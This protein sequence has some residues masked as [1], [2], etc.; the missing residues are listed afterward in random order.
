MMHG[1]YKHSWMRIQKTA[2][3]TTHNPSVTA[4]NRVSD[5]EGEDAESQMV[6][7]QA[8]MRQIGLTSDHY[9]RRSEP[10]PASLVAASS[11]C[12]MPDASI[13]ELLQDPT[14]LPHS[15]EAI[16]LHCLMTDLCRDFQSSSLAASQAENKVAVTALSTRALTL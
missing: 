2:W 8:L 5:A 12:A 11:I 10:L 15:G 7:R 16:P 4:A 14:L 1:S 13:Y 9:L 3:A 6:Q